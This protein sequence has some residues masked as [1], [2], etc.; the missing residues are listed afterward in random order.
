MCIRD[1]RVLDLRAR[2]LIHDPENRIE[3]FANRFC[4]RPPGQRFGDRIQR[5][6]AT[7]GISCDDAIP[8][9]GEGDAKGFSP[10]SGLP[11]GATHRFAEGDNN[12]A[13]TKIRYEPYELRDV[14][15][16]DLAARFYKEIR[17]RKIT[18]NGIN[19]G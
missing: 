2:F 11:L 17:T 8:D 13:G 9:T 15:G 5:S 3:R 1:S 18:K 6:N 14:T 7:L 19:D 12:C 4:F 16:K 10:D